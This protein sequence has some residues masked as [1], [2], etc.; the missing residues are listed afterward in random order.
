M[1]PNTAPSDDARLAR[2]QAFHDRRFGGE[3]QRDAQGKYYWAV[4]HGRTRLNE[5]IAALAPGADLLEYGCATGAWAVDF[6]SS[7]RSLTGIDISPVAIE[8]ATARGL[9]NCAFQVM[10]AEAMSFQDASFD[11]VYGA[12]ILHHLDLAR[13]SAD[14]ARV[15][16]P[17]GR[18]LFWEPLGHN[19]L[20]NAYRRA[21]PA[22]RTEDEHPLLRRDIKT[23][24]KTFG[25]ISLSLYGLT[26]LASVP[27][28]NTFLGKPLRRVGAAV[29]AGLFRLPG[30]RWQAWYALIDM[31]RTD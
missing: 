19:V 16:R 13:A 27:F 7:S 1:R 23:L 3:M 12:G 15:L 22:A 24:R 17:G 8:A 26:T 28:R 5:K 2:E 10:N 6:A 11:V 18:A 29:D 9:P 14:I 21:T 25:H 31:R 20:I 30:I 4:E